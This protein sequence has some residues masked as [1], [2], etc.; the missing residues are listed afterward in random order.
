MRQSLRSFGTSAQPDRV[1]SCRLSTVPQAEGLT[2]T[3]QVRRCARED[4]PH[5]TRPVKIPADT[6][7]TAQFTPAR[8]PHLTGPPNHGTGWKVSAQTRLT[9]PLFNCDGL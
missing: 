5:S 9:P 3:P 1:V 2:R 8:R 7:L 6:R 4:V